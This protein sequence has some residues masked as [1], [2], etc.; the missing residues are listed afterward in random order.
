MWLFY[1]KTATCNCQ[2][3]INQSGFRKGKKFYKISQIGKMDRIVNE[4]SGLAKLT[5]KQTFWSHNDSGGKAELYEVDSTGNY[6]STLNIPKARN[7]DWEDLASDRQGNIFIGDFGNNRNNR[8]DLTIYKLSEKEPEKVKTIQ[9]SYED[10]NAF[11]PPD[12]ERNFDCEAMFYHQDSL[13]LFS[14][15]RGDKQVKLYVVPAAEGTYSARLKAKI[16]L[17]TMVTG[18][19]ISPDEKK[20]AVLTYGKLFIFGINEGQINFSNPIFCLK[21]KRKQTEAI[22]FLDND[23]LLLTNEQGSIY[24]IGQRAAP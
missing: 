17:K 22:V 5:G 7:I 10:Q 11:P 8:K 2:S 6:I 15:N 23:R 4:S 21:T 14:K 20:F 9:F 24:L 12:K 1:L 16:Y 13:Y 19:D 3:E 18:A